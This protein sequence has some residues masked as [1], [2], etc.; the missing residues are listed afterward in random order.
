M[1]VLNPSPRRSSCSKDREQLSRGG[2]PGFLC[3]E[4]LLWC[5][6]AREL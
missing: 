6:E 4:I 1:R 5:Q 3:A 2:F